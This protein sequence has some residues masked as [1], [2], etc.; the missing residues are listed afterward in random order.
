M[1]VLQ[2]HE[3]ASLA[4]RKLLAEA[5]SDVTDSFFPDEHVSRRGFQ[6]KDIST[7]RPCV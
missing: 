7:T 4:R 2:G 1:P 3:L 6:Q 5:Q